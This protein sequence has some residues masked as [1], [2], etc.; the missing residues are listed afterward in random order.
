MRS[1]R[2]QVSTTDDATRRQKATDVD[3]DPWRDLLPTIVRAKTCV[4]CEE[5]RTCAVFKRWGYDRAVICG[6]CALKAALAIT[7]T[8][9]KRR[10]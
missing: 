6:F 3:A 5:K 8:S 4:A 7:R 2:N 1:K 10:H 9:L